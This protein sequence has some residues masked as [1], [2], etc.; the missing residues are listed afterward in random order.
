MK[1]IIY[2]RVSTNKEEQETSLQRQKE[3]LEQLA[4]TYRFQVVKVIEERASG[5]EIERDGILELLEALK[6]DKIEAVLIQDETRLGRGNARIALLH[7][8]QKEGAKLYTVCHHGELQ[9]SEADSMVLSILSIVEE[10]Q[11]K[12]HNLKIKRGMQKAVERGYRPE[13]NLKNIGEHAGRDRLELPIEEIIRLRRNGLTFAEIA[14]T[15]R[16]FG[17]DVSKATVHRRYQEYERKSQ[18]T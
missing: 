10:Y 7:C 5:Y 1:A 2:C 16:G 3:E 12:I 17:Y 18:S 15:L 8:I 11:R 4:E 14:A 6:E 9:L 13:R